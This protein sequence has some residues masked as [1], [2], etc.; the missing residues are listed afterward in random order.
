MTRA[1]ARRRASCTIH[2]NPAPDAARGFTLV[3]VLVALV[4]AAIL[5]S[6]L[7]AMQQHGLNQASRAD[8]LWLHLNT[9]QEALMGRNIGL[10]TS[11]LVSS[12]GLASGATPPGGMAPSSVWITTSPPTPKWPSPWL[13]L[14]TRVHGQETQWSWP[15]TSP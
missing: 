5:A 9:A 8:V 3:E 2:P 4:I 14:T 6:G 12:N 15:V 1:L 10:E 11:S 7:L 13:T